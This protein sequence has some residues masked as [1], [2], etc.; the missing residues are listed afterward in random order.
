M[1]L[2]Y[3]H[4]TLLYLVLRAA[5]HG[6]AKLLASSQLGTHKF[7][8]FQNPSNKRLSM[9]CT[10]LFCNIYHGLTT[11]R[12]YLKLWRQFRDLFFQ[13]LKIIKK[14]KCSHIYPC[15]TVVTNSYIKKEVLTLAIWD[16]KRQ[17]FIEYSR[18]Y[19]TFICVFFIY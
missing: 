4:K 1:K 7:Y 16:S 13:L 10:G 19:L 2:E 9:F 3:E 12:K 15:H 18:K 8:I 14:L 6:C 17:K 11:S 5:I